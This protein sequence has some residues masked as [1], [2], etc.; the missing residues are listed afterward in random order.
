MLQEF[1]FSGGARRLVFAYAGLV[2]FI[3]HSV[4][5]AWIKVALNEWYE[6]FYDAVGDTEFEH[7]S[8]FGDKRDEVWGLLLS[9]ALIVSP[10]IVVH[11]LARWIGSVWCYS[12]RMALIR[13]YLSHWDCT[14]IPLEGAAQRVHEDTQRFAEGLHSCFGLVLDSMC[15][16]IAFV[17]VLLSLGSEVHLPG[18]EWRPWLLTIAA[19][20]A[21]GGLCVS[22]VVG[23]KLVG[24]EVANQV[25]EARLRTK[26]VLLEQT[27]VAI[28]GGLSEVRDADFVNI[29]VPPIVKQISPYYALRGVLQDLWSNYRRL[30]CQFAMFNTWLSIYDQFMILLPYLLVAPLLFAE[31]AGDRITLGTLMKMSNAFG[32]CFDAMAIVSENWNAVNAWRSVLYRLGEFEQTMYTRVNFS[33]TRIHNVE[34]CEVTATLEVER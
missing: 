10:T 30:Y 33:S 20:A 4:F 28:C 21:M 34:L 22:M 9:F 6:E 19:C 8:G 26:L 2:I 12:W 13:S 25:V 29:E 23:W 7:T 27:P 1:F 31:D 17:P 14:M 32:R 15:T 16:L 11:P 3:G 5:K 24:L 18:F